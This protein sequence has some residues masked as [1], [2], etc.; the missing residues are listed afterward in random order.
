MELHKS[1]AQSNQSLN[2]GKS[3]EILDDILSHQRSPFIK[4]VFYTWNIIRPFRKNQAE[5]LKKKKMKENHKSYANF[6]KSPFNNERGTRKGDEL[7]SRCDFLNGFVNDESI[8]KKG[9]EDQ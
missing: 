6:L 2:F 5:S 8:T 4:W 9:D 3:V 1:N 7:Q